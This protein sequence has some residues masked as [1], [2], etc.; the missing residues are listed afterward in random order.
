MKAK[1]TYDGIEVDIEVKEQDLE[2]MG[3][4]K[5]AEYPELS[6]EDYYVISNM[7]RTCKSYTRE[8][9]DTIDKY[10]VYEPKFNDIPNILESQ[11][12]FIIDEY[13]KMCKESWENENINWDNQ[14]QIKFHM[15][16]DRQSKSLLLGYEQQCT[17]LN[18][19]FRSKY[20]MMGFIAKYGEERIIKAMFS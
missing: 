15:F 14:K 4:I 9:S 17:I 1:I 5:T 6:K 7:V 8:L 13:E 16:F 12:W 11:K 19:S 3:L 20:D 2:N 10:F 18:R